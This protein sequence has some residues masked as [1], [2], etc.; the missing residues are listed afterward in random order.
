MLE[1][2]LLEELEPLAEDLL[3]IFPNQPPVLDPLESDEV[4]ICG[5]NRRFE[6]GLEEVEVDLAEHGAWAL[7]LSELQCK[8][9]LFVELLNP[10]NLVVGQTLQ[11]LPLRLQLFLELAPGLLPAFEALFS[12]VD[13]GG[14]HCS[15]PQVFLLLAG[16]FLSLL[17]GLF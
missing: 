17:P 2:R 10:G 1:E 16:V 13:R 11:P 9:V 3:L 7:R 6:P 15:L 8:D 5:A 4:R 12:A 14:L